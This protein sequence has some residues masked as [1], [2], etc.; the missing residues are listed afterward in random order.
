MGGAT[1]L[2]GSEESSIQT[3][4]TMG[5]SGRGVERRKALG[6]HIPSVYLPSVYVKTLVSRD[7]WIE[8]HSFGFQVLYLNMSKSILISGSSTETQSLQMAR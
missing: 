7:N 2:G 8:F 1:A 4:L 3:G 5:R 6:T